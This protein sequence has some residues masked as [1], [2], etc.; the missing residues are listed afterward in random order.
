MLRWERFVP[1]VPVLRYLNGPVGRQENL[2]LDQ[3]IESGSTP[4]LVRRM[5]SNWFWQKELSHFLI[6]LYLY[7]VNIITKNR[8]E[9][10]IIYIKVPEK[11]IVDRLYNFSMKE[12]FWKKTIKFLDSIVFRTNIKYLYFIYLRR[13]SSNV[14]VVIWFCSVM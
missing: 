14:C 13:N 6:I 5:T 12:K 8:L 3:L 1:S 4:L 7:R 10:T 11:E 2:L 9:L